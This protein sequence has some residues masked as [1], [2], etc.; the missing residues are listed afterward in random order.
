[1]VHWQQISLFY[2]KS[3]Y[4]KEYESCF[5][6]LYKSISIKTSLSEI[7]L[8]FI[9]FLCKLLDINT[10]VVD[11]SIYEVS[12]ERSQKLINIFKQDNANVYLSGPAAKKYLDKSTF[13]NAGIEIQWMD[14]NYPEY[15]QLHGSF[16]LN[17]SVIDLI[18]NLGPA[19]K[20]FL[21]RNR[22]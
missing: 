12:G 5:K 9:H 11:S 1:M 19:A 3:P 8:E 18:F 20:K 15:K 10:E 21:S 22:P 6:E 7:N 17:I 14:Y 13:E 2:K 16:T 4:F